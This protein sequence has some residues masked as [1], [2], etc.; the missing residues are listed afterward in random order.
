MRGEIRR[1]L[2]WLGIGTLV[3]GRGGRPLQYP[4][5]RSAPSALQI[6]P[7]DC[8]PVAQISDTA[9][10]RIAQIDLHQ[11]RL[12]HAGVLMKPHGEEHSMSDD[13]YL[14]GSDGSDIAF[15]I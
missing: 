14:H 1:K 10:A 12:R 15:W 7:G 11:T 3:S 9:S 8:D 13:Y 6:V 5:L 4:Q 2:K